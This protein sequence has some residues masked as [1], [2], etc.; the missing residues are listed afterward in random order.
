MESAE[1][2]GALLTA[3]I[4]PPPVT[5]AV[6]W[7]EIFD[8]DA[9]SEASAL[10]GRLQSGRSAVSA[11]LAPS[12]TSSSL[13]L[14]GLIRA[15]G[16]YLPEVTTLLETL[17]RQDAV[18]TKKHLQFEWSGSFAAPGAAA[19]KCPF[20]IFEVCMCLQ[21]LGF[22]NYSQ[23]ARVLLQRIPSSLDPAVELKEASNAFLAA[24]SY[25]QC[26]GRSA[27]LRWVTRKSLKRVTPDLDEHAALALAHMAQAAAQQCA[28]GMALVTGNSKPAL[29]S[30]LT[31][32]VVSEA[33]DC[34][35]CLGKVDTKSDR[36]NPEVS[37][38]AAY[39][40]ELFSSVSLLHHAR[41]LAEGRKVGEAIS[42][43]EQSIGKLKIQSGTGPHN[44]S[45]PGLPR[46]L[47][48]GPI[49]FAIGQLLTVVTELRD[50][51]T[52]ENDLLYFQVI[53]PAALP[54]GIT[55]S[56]PT[57][58]KMP[59]AGKTISF[60]KA[61]LDSVFSSLSVS[62]TAAA[63]TAAPAAAPAATPSAAAPAAA[64]AAVATWAC[65]ACTFL[66]PPEG[67]VCE[68]CGLQRAATP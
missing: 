64:P 16:L 37:A 2:R 18:V 4:L 36:V 56:T 68:M 51:C 33:V 11:L 20:I 61:P 48:R 10:L 14:S 31:A 13:D 62:A 15:L 5:S 7:L 44:P 22:A 32:A 24:A 6:P 45:E 67:P 21:S 29:L 40:R 52:R 47:L 63:A 28:V 57:E 43:L 55:V 25:W 58:F 38:H 8:V 23:G 65:S 41:G 30:K 59:S 39:L 53:A 1:L 60:H 49:E 26:L 19:L 35:A 12:G 9:G 34:L 66:N 42:A 50:K 17:D 54:A 3:M 27:L 46:S